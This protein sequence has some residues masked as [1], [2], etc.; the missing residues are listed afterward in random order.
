[1]AEQIRRSCI[2]CG[3]GNCDHMD[4]TY[5][6][7]CLTTNMDEELKQSSID[8]YEDEENKKI[9][10]ESEE[11]EYENYCKMTRVEET[12]EFAKKIGAHKI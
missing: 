8:A 1:M 12:M 2:D 5:P 4:K 11:V 9:M 3:I 6:G 7:F 10:I